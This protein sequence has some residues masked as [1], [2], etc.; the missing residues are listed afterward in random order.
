MRHA[1]AESGRRRPEDAGERITIRLN[2]EAREVP[3]GSA[4]DLLKFLDIDTRTVVVE[5]NRAIIRRGEL[6]LAYIKESDEVEL[7]HFVGGG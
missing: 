1:A 2:G 6:A 3:P 4:L 5:I 7:V